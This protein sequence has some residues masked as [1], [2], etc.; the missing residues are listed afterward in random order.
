MLYLALW[1]ISSEGANEHLFSSR[2][3]ADLEVG[4]ISCTNSS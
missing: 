2:M 1:G 3:D 4:A